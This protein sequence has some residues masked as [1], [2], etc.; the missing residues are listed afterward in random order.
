MQNHVAQPSEFNPVYPN[1]EHRP[2]AGAVAPV[3]WPRL[4][5]R[6]AVAE[7][8][9]VSERYV[10]TMVESGLIPGPKLN[11]SSRCILWDRIEID[12]WLDDAAPVQPGHARSFD[13]L[14][15]SAGSL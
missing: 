9:S 3:R 15:A 12:R 10:D 11:P 7:Y 4:L 2:D 13:D 1:T 5:R 8:L 6:P 14:V